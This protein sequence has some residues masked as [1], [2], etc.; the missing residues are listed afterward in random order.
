M[1][2]NQEKIKMIREETY[3]DELKKKSKSFFDLLDGPIKFATGTAVVIGIILSILQYKENSL[4]QRYEAARDFQKTFYQEQ[5]TVYAEAVNATAVLSTIDPDHI[6]YQ[7]AREKFYELFWGRMSMFEDKCVEARMVEFRRLL[8][9]FERKDF[10]PDTIVDPCSPQVCHIDTVT[11]VML[12]FA[13]LRLAHECRRYTIKT[14]LPANEQ[15][16]YNLID[17]NFCPHN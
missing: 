12:K 2:S 10:H 1:L 4:H 6:E 13:S 9:K 5:M 16:N 8:I 11:Q 7:K 14:W 17:S 15:R 3:R